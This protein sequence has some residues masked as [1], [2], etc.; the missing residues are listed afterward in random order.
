ME[1]LQALPKVDDVLR[2]PELSGSGLPR[3]ALL[4]AVRRALAARR[5]AL[6]GGGDADPALS[7]DEVLAAA[8]ALTRPSL[9]RVINATGVVLH[10]GLGRAPLAGHA[11]GRA[12]LLQPRIRPRRAGPRIAPRPPAGPAARGLRRRGR[13]HGQQRRGRGA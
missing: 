7:S 3:W 2:R 10:T 1:R 5:Q 8:R 11:A 4:E 9:R 13:P 12:R 6:V